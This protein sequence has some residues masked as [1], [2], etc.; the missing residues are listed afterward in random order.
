METPSDD[1][2]S[3][4]VSLEVGMK[5]L[6]GL[7]EPAERWRFVA[8]SILRAVQQQQPIRLVYEVLRHLYEPECRPFERS[9]VDT[10]AC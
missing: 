6:A 10:Y 1:E 4:E 9:S 8:A 2:G 5:Q 3:G 7:R